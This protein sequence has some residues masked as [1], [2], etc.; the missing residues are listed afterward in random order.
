MLTQKYVDKN[1]T[2][3]KYNNYKIIIKMNITNVRYA[4]K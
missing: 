3:K 2:A 1:T 4:M